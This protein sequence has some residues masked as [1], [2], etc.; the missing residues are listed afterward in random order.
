MFENLVAYA[1][2]SSPEEI[3]RIEIEEMA[4]IAA[5]YH[6]YEGNSE[7]QER[8]PGI[9]DAI[10]HWIGNVKKDDRVTEGRRL[11]PLLRHI[12]DQVVL[13]GT[14]NV[15]RSEL[16]ILVE[17]YVLLCEV[18]D[19]E[20]F[21]RLALFFEPK[22]DSIKAQ[23]N[24]L[25]LTPGLVG[26][27]RRLTIITPEDITA[28]R[29]RSVRSFAGVKM[30]LRGPVYQ[31]SG[32][33]KVIGMVP[34]DCMLV[35]DEGTCLVNGYVLGHVAA[36]HGCEVRDNIS[37][38]VI[39]RDGDI[40]GRNVLTN[41]FVVS[42]WGSIHVRLSENPKL[43]FAGN[44]IRI[45]EG[46]QHGSYA[47]P[48]INVT[49]EATG[50]EYSVSKQLSAKKFQ[51]TDA[52][53]LVIALRRKITCEDYGG[54]VDPEA[55]R[56]LSLI[57]KVRRRRDITQDMIVLAEDEADHFASSAL[58]SLAGGEDIMKQ[59]EE[60]NHSHSRIALLDRLIAAV[61]MMSVT[62][63]EQLDALHDPDRA[64]A[65]QATK[66][67]SIAN[68]QDLQAELRRTGE[69]EGAD[70]DLLKEGEDLAGI[71]RELSSR[72]SDTPVPAKILFLLW[73]KKAG[74]L[75]DRQELSANAT[76]KASGIEKLLGD[77]EILRARGE[78]LSDMK[79]LSR[80]L[81]VAYKREAGDR[82]FD[83][84]NTSFVQLMLR[85]IESRKLRVREY[86]KTL[87]MLEKELK[88]EYT[89]LERECHIPPPP[90]HDQNPSPASVTGKFGKDVT[91]CIDRFLLEEKERPARS[92]LQT[93][94]SGN[95]TVRYAREN[96]KIV[97]VETD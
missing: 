69:E 58:I 74:W 68:I 87:E 52:R 82:L 29:P 31:G 35:V 19:K 50:G 94:A 9:P 70:E 77:N 14:E 64:A 92:V 90:E 91:I 93:E 26:V 41:A 49:E 95:A 24:S 12:L 37:G 60:V 45:R 75:L 84:A 7:R 79:L 56:I 76:R 43:L 89:R 33:V 4:I 15:H 28:A 63:E 55:T 67:Q 80:L 53:K 5:W 85:S 17:A 27:G 88:M 61:D 23:R 57:G 40:R 6:S 96:D 51:A 48:E 66:K 8:Y 97:K 81:A 36:S 62:V 65:I 30:S 10:R 22:I 20:I 1:S 71:A 46:A 34:D 2:K 44:E 59:I 11:Q 18:S 78:E 3:A 38:V 72:I 42:K 16:D 25:P 73:E 39:V 13:Y 86:T 21:A 83:R 47:S 32:D 54:L